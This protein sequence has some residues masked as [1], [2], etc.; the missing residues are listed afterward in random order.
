ME[1]N[2]M[3]MPGILADIAD[4]AGS[5]AA[6]AI[7]EQKGGVT[8]YFPKVDSLSAGHWLVQA[9]GMDAARKIARRVGGSRVEVPRGTQAGNRARVHSTI[10]EGLVKG[11]PMA[12]VA[13]LAGVSVRTVQRH[14]SRLEREGMPAASSEVVRHG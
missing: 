10:R 11:M 6:L 9:V 8:A 7:A 4:A 12:A 13:R 1:A 2:C 14:K 5:E 3:P